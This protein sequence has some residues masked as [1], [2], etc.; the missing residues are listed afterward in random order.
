MKN[1]SAVRMSEM[2]GNTNNLLLNKSSTMSCRIFL[3][4]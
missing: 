3:R 2:E 1:N 4:T